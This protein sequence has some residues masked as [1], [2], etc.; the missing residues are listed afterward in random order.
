MNKKDRK[1][2]DNMIKEAWNDESWHQTIIS[3]EVVRN[4]K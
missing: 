4:G 1:A 2:I 3:K